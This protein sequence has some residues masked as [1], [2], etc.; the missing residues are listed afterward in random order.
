M[1]ETTSNVEGEQ[2]SIE[3]AESGCESNS[4]RDSRDVDLHVESDVVQ[5][6][7]SGQRHSAVDDGVFEDED[8]DALDE[9]LANK[10]SNTDH[11][12]EQPYF[13]S[14]FKCRRDKQFTGSV[15][16]Q[17]EET[18]E[19][20]TPVTPTKIRMQLSGGGSTTAGSSPEETPQ[21]GGPTANEVAVALVFDRPASPRSNSGSRSPSCDRGSRLNG[22]STDRLVAPNFAD[23]LFRRYGS[24]MAAWRVA[25]DVHKKGRIS[26]SDF[27]SA[28]RSNLEM[29]WPG[30]LIWESLGKDVFKFLEMHEISP[31]EGENLELFAELL[32]SRVGLDADRAWAALHPQKR[33][34]LNFEDFKRGVTKLGYTGDAK[35]LFRGLDSSRMGKVRAS[36]I[37][38]AIKISRV[39]RERLGGLDELQ[40]QFFSW[41]QYSFGSPDHFIKK[42]KLA[43]GTHTVSANELSTRLAALG[44]PGDTVKVVRKTAWCRDGATANLNDLN[45]VLHGRSTVEEKGSPQRRK[46]SPSPR[47]RSAQKPT[48]QKPWDEHLH[49]IS[50]TNKANCKYNKTYFDRQNCTRSV[51]R[52]PITSDVFSPSPQSSVTLEPCKAPPEEGLPAWDTSPNN[53]KLFRSFSDK[54]IKQEL[55]RLI[56]TGMTTERRRELLHRRLPEAY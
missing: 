31:E 54:P 50:G 16:D 33:M 48:I 28:C 55:Q 38:Y 53:G 9:A 26:Y 14:P 2:N 42:L 35:I 47:P 7:S 6:A 30:K 19:K 44:F 39:G 43:P 41:V 25:L 4:G 51:C 52:S 40:K 15:M 46:P 11:A 17:L 1:Q 12:P 56:A 13:Y 5:T 3:S 29:S 27:T 24:T 21:R 22:E 20:S 8:D 49:D 37:Q 32:W 10:Q 34:H 23:Y 36:D 18:S 45:N